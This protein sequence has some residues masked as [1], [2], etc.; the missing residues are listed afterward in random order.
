MSPISALSVISSDSI[1]GSTS[2]ARIASRTISRLVGRR[3]WRAERL[4]A[5]S[6]QSR[7]PCKRVSARSSLSACSSAHVPMGTIIP[8]SSAI[9]MNSDGR[10][11]AVAGAVPPQQRLGADDAA[12]GQ[13]HDRLVEELELLALDGLPERGLDVEARG[14]LLLQLVAEQLDAGPPEVLGAVH[15]G[16]GVAQELLGGCPGAAE[17]DA[18]ARGGEQLATRQRDRLVQHLDDAFGE[19]DR[20][21]DVLD[22]L[23]HDHELV[24]AEPGD[25]VG[26]ADRA[27]EPSRDLEQQLVA[28]DVT[29]TVVHELE[30]VEVEE[31][32]GDVAVPVRSA[33]ASESA[34]RSTRSN[35]LGRCVRSSC[36]AWCASA[37]S[38]R[39]RSVMSRTCM[40][41]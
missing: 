21:G 3:S 26:R 37:S 34:S 36:S 10:I 39:L 16:V 28:D 13:A 25:G 23:A 18:H 38:A 5:S 30:A 41:K 31:E 17:C 22:V 35:R 14:D 15:G 32:H 19:L 24:A 29:E 11:D 12:V 6:G 4:T 20:F 27:H 40:K 7:S 9:G 8:V 2:D 1:D 33:R